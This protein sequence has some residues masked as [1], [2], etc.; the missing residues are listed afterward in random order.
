VPNI[1]TPFQHNTGIPIQSNKARRRNKRIQIGKVTDKISLF[2][3]DMILYL[4][5]QKT[6]SQ[7]SQTP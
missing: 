1:P 2:A 7:N 5:T 4:K 6:L 3:E